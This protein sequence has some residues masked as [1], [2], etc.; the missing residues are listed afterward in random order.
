MMMT[1]VVLMTRVL[2]RSIV[3]ESV[4][5]LGE[6]WEAPRRIPTQVVQTV[7]HARLATV[8]MHGLAGQTWRRRAGG[9]IPH[10]GTALEI[11]AASAAS[12]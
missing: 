7:L 5:D 3:A 4:T 6:T 11:S 2:S 12:R 10:C 9:P 8:F 1:I